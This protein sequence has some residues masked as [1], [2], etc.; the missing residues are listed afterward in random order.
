MELFAESSLLKNRNLESARLRKLLFVN[1]RPL[2]CLHCHRS[3]KYR[4]SLQLHL[5]E[6]HKVPLPTQKEKPERK[7]R[8]QVKSLPKRPILRAK[9]PESYSPPIGQSKSG[10]RVSVITKNPYVTQ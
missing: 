10:R 8:V 1:T 9:L 5:F 2:R 6:A 7:M 4:H 3:Y